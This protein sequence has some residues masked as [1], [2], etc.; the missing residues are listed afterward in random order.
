MVAAAAADVASFSVVVVVVV[1]VVRF[2]NSPWWNERSFLDDFDVVQ[3]F[4]VVPLGASYLLP[5]ARVT[6]TTITNDNLPTMIRISDVCDIY[7]ND[8]KFSTKMTTWLDQSVVG[9]DCESRIKTP[10]IL[11]VI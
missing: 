5:V 4:V 11:E 3:E 7:I 8:L 2:A 9:R 6:I 10:F 1:A